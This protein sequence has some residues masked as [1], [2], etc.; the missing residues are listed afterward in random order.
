M[1]VS[2][3]TGNHLGRAFPCNMDIDHVVDGHLEILLP[4]LLDCSAYTKGRRDHGRTF[5]G[6]CLALVFF[7]ER[8][9]K[10]Q[11]HSQ[12]LLPFG[13]TS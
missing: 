1:F 10:R 2:Q 8:Y 11:D 7:R 12:S 13:Q 9:E 3:R 5:L 4:S 6:S